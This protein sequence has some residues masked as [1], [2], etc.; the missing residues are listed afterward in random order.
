M[1]GA[2][3]STCRIDVS[4]LKGVT[5]TLGRST[6][7]QHIPN[8]IVCEC[9]DLDV[10]E[11]LASA[12]VNTHLPVRGWLCRKCDEHQGNALVK[13][14]D[15]EAEVRMR[16]AETIDELHATQGLADDYRDRMKAA[17]RSRDAVLQQ[18]ERLER[19]HGAT[20]HGCICG[21]RNCETLAIVDTDWIND[22]IAAMHRHNQAS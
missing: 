5:P 16:W 12:V 15:H 14:Q 13:A 7:D 3:E 21:K 9:C 10:P 20:P 8:T 11:R 6:M 2:P 19:Y 1:C 18:F 4:P 22:R 17:S